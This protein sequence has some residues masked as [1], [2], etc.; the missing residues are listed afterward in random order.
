MRVLLL[1]A[2]RISY[3][4]VEEAIRNPPDPQSSGEYSNCLVA[5]VTVEE[6]DGVEE[7]ERAAGDTILQANRLGLKTILIYPYAHLS[8]SL[9]PPPEAYRVLVALEQ[10]I[11]SRWEGEVYRA[12]FGWYKAFE[13]SCPGH[14]LAE[15]SRQFK[16]GL[17]IKYLG[18]PLEEAPLKGL[19]EKWLLDRDPWSA[20]TKELVSRFDVDGPH[21]ITMLWELES[22]L[23]EE[24]G[25]K[26]RVKVPAPETVYGLVGAAHLAYTCSKW[27]GEGLTLFWGGLGDSL[28]SSRSPP[29]GFLETLNK[30]LLEDSITVNLGSGGLEAGD[31][32][33]RVTLY[34]ARKG[35]AVPLI[36]EVEKPEGTL[37]CLGPTR[38]IAIAFLDA[39]LK[40]A[41]SGT[42]PQIPFWLAPI[43]VALIPVSGAQLSYA[44]SIA[45][46]LSTMRVRARILKE[47]SLGARIRDSGRLWTPLVVV[48]GEREASTNTVTLRRRWE[49]GKQEVV[50]LEDFIEEVSKLN[51]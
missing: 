41:D 27:G 7:A 5:F 50:S 9:A 18:V 42:T 17:T 15:L 34:K 24:F 12:P 3:R 20:E 26:R 21:G 13:L 6:G 46:K 1:H 16:A 32:R 35:G 10:T 36:V 39:G 25:V 43:Q 2:T 44:D 19:V 49:P 40:D 45:S 47:G 51:S 33:G 48:L 28:V 4:T 22:R 38:S 31:I 37:Y 8:S 30:R 11:R 29:A 14:P 23:S